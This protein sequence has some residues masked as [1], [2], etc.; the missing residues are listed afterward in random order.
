MSGNSTSLAAGLERGE[1]AKELPIVVGVG[2]FVLGGVTGELLGQSVPVRR[3]TAVLSVEAAVLALAAGV[4]FG[5][6]NSFSGACLLAFAMGFQNT[7]VS[8]NSAFTSALTYVTGA[9]VHMSKGLAQ[10][11]RGHSS[12]LAAAQ[13]G[14][15][16]LSLM[17][18]ALGGATVAEH[19]A[20]AAILAA[21]IL[22]CLAAV[23]LN[24]GPSNGPSPGNR[25]G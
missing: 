6:G 19:S 9:L 25:C 2:A 16:W 5:D 20:P 18:G 12:W 13:Y 23:G 1:F 4:T 15:L 10:A 8:P 11:L 17:V 7:C 14:C 24:P 21:A 3:W 22:V